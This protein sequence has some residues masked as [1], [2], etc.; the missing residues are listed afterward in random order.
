MLRMRYITLLLLILVVAG[1]AG[2]K[3]RAW[4][5]HDIDQLTLSWGPPDAEAILK[6]GK[7]VHTYYLTST[8]TVNM[9]VGPDGKIDDIAILG[10]D[11]TTMLRRPISRPPS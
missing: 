7:A 2:S 5:G 3:I 8:C 9:T 6:D 1:C 11:C 10:T 4:E